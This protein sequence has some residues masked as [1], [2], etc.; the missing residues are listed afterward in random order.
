MGLWQKN[1]RMYATSAYK[2]WLINGFSPNKILENR[3]ILCYGGTDLL[4]LL[5]RHGK[6]RKVK[7][8]NKRLLTRKQQMN[9]GEMRWEYFRKACAVITFCFMPISFKQHTANQ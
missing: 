1:I 5:W 2:L 9:T 3:L 8:D 7:K 4:T 6:L